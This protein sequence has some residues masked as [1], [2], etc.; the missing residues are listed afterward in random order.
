M[1]LLGRATARVPARHP[2]YPRPY[3]DYD[4]CLP[5]AVSLYGRG[6]LGGGVGT[7]AVAL[8]HPFPFM[9]YICGAVMDTLS[10]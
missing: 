4:I 5:C 10:L 7:L 1:L 2:L 8:P 3:N 6:W 9:S